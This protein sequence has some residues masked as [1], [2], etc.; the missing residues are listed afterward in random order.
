ADGDRPSAFGGVVPGGGLDRHLVPAAARADRLH[1][2]GLDHE[3]VEPVAALLLALVGVVGDHRDDHLVAAGDGQVAALLVGDGGDQPGGGTGFVLAAEHVGGPVEGVHPVGQI[4]VGLERA[5][6]G[7]A[8][9][10]DDDRVDR[11][12]VA[13]VGAVDRVGVRLLP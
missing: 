2:S 13:L 12:L 3:L 7:I 1:V 10:R 9:A 6:G 11:G 4:V 5:L 8:G